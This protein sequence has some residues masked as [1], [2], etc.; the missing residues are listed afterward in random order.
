MKNIINLIVKFL[1]KIFSRK[2]PSTDLISHPKIKKKSFLL[3][4]IENMDMK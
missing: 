2:K 1:Q 4:S 3:N